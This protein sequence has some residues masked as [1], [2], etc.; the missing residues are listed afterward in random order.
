MRRLTTLA[1]ALV[2]LGG[3]AGCGG[4][5]SSSSST[6]SE[7]GTLNEEST[8]PDFMNASLAAQ[9]AYAEK[10]KGAYPQGTNKESAI[11]RE[12]K[13]QCESEKVV[14][15]GPEHIGEVHGEAP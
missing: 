12:V 15:G 1:V 4:S 8:C 11:G 3:V 10:Y 5:G 2:L 14:G 9:N 13:D 7:A 6:S